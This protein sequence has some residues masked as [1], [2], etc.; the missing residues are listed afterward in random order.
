MSERVLWNAGEFF[1]MSSTEPV[2]AGDM[3]EAVRERSKAERAATWLLRRWWAIAVAAL[4][5]ALAGEI[6]SVGVALV[7]E[8]AQG[9]PLAWPAAQDTALVSL[10]LHHPAITIA[11]STGIALLTGAAFM[12]NRAETARL[13][14]VARL[15]AAELRE[16]RRVE[17]RQ[18]LQTFFAEQR[19]QG[20]DEDAATEGMPAPVVALPPRPTLVVGRDAALARI[21]ELLRH[22]GAIA[23][24]GMGGAGKSTVLMETLHREVAAQA[25]P[26]VVW[27]SCRGMTADDGETQLLDAVGVALGAREVGKAQGPGTKSAMLARHLA[28]ARVLIGLDNVESGLPLDRVLPALMARDAAGIGPTVLLSTRAAWNDIPNLT[29]VPLSELPVAE[30]VALLRELILRGGGTIAPDDE[31]DLAAIVEAVGALPLALEMVAPRIARRSESPEALAVRLHQEGA[32]LRGR[33]RGIEHTFA[34]TYAP[35]GEVERRV[36]C[37]LAALGG[38][39]FSQEAALSVAMALAGDGVTFQSLVDLADL[40]LIRETPQP[41]GPPRYAMHPLLHQFARERLQG[42]GSEQEYTVEAAAARHYRAV[43]HRRGESL[44]ARHAMMDLE[45]PNIVAAVTWAYQQ[46]R[47]A[48]DDHARRLLA[49][50]V[51][52]IIG[53]TRRFISERGYWTEAR[54]LFQWGLEVD[55]FLGN[56]ARLNALLV[57]L[58]FIAREQGNLDEAEHL[59]QRALDLA[60][61]RNDSLGEAARI[62]NLGTIA[63]LRGDL[64]LARAR[65]EEALAMRRARHDDGGTSATLRAL[66]TVAASEGEYAAARESLHAALEIKRATGVARGRTMCELGSV[67]VRDPAGDRA[68]ARKLLRAALEIARQHHVRFDEATALDWL[69]ALELEEGRMEAARQSWEAALIIYLSL[70]ASAVTRTRQRLERLDHA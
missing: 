34:L 38:P 57:D 67:L 40:S 47:A 39:T 48:S 36:F 15:D 25:F 10:S 70:G 69:G 30:G 19:G 1:L 6:S 64:A 33:A 3:A 37:A 7:N 14:R 32:R 35:L 44:E 31:P 17:T 26:S 12:A 27:I 65:Y 21:A 24:R 60:R 4:G 68:Q 62:H 59:Y 58:A 45:Y 46:F 2:S 8:Y 63:R 42:M 61:S 56:P 22:G 55:A 5:S 51:G 41:Q 49:E 13:A 43:A 9:K 66:G 54:H 16:A 52:D 23:L 20:D 11:G 28:G 50:M 18:V 29:E 53:D